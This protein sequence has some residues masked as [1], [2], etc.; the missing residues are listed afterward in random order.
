VLEGGE[1]PGTE[2]GGRLRAGGGV[3]CGREWGEEDQGAATAL[4]I[5]ARP[6]SLE[7][8]GRKR[9]RLAVYRNVDTQLACQRP[10]KKPSARQS[11]PGWGYNG[12]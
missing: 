9:K 1:R 8:R 2:K 5:V 3:T 12:P 6:G 7:E 10:R 11:F 4:E